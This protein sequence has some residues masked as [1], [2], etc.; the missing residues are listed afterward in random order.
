[1]RKEDLEQFDLIV[2]MDRENLRDLKRLD[3]KGQWAGKIAPMCFFSRLVFRMKKCR[4]PIMGGQE[5]FE[6]VV[7]L[8]QDGCGNLLER[9]K[10]QLSL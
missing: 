2:G 3:K 1:M 7:K 4:I 5:G 10:E 9:L 6:Y 8:L